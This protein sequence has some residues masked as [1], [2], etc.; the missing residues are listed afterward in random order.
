MVFQR[1][2]ASALF[3]GEL[4]DENKLWQRLAA[5]FLGTAF[6][7]F[8]GVGSVPALAAARGTAPFT[9]S[10]LGFISLS[11]ATIVVVTVYVFGYVS[12]NH[13]NPAVTVGFAVAGKFPWK[14]VPHY[15][16][17]Q[18]IGA[19]VGALGIVG[20][21]G[22]SAVKVGLGVAAFNPEVT[23]VP[24]ALLAEF[25]GTFILV[26][27]VFGAVFRKAAA[28]WAGLVIGLAVFAA[29][30]PVAPVTGASINPARTIGPMLV[31]QALGGEVQWNQL[32]V[33]LLAE[34]LGGVA[35]A[36]AFALVTHT[37]LDKSNNIPDLEVVAK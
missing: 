36:L 18:A 13:I 3:K 14:E 8:V 11:F 10:E 30:I 27:A 16:A 2:S 6:L 24:Q 12:G 5:E 9:G 32:W 29:I 1:G 19:I 26:Y 17:A 31:L 7:V 21:L 15:L 37:A 35:A 25:V 4:V 20:V 28:G 22:N 34:F 23:T 33:Y